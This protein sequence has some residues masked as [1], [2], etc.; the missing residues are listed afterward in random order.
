MIHFVFLSFSDVI[1]LSTP[2]CITKVSSHSLSQIFSSD[3]SFGVRFLQSVA[4]S[5][6]SQSNFSSPPSLLSPTAPQSPAPSLYGSLSS[7]MFLQEDDVA[8]ERR[9]LL[10]ANDGL[11][12]SLLASSGLKV[13]CC[14]LGFWNTNSL[15][16]SLWLDPSSFSYLCCQYWVWQRY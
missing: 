1:A 7:S 8:L 4:R 13:A 9:R 12:F 15:F 5:V 10:K 3:P 2:T 11:S 14:Q 16:F 6:S